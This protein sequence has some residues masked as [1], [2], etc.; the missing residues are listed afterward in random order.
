MAEL[1]DTDIRERVRERYFAAARQIADPGRMLRSTDR[2]AAAAGHD[3]RQHGSEVFGG[4]ALRRRRH[5]GARR[6]SRLRSAAACPPRSPTCARARLCS[7]WARAP[8]PTC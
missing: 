2:H 4:N 8:A 5:P 3:N 1:D 7:T 6:L